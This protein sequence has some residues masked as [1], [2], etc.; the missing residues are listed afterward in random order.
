MSYDQFRAYVEIHLE[1]LKR[2]S[3]DHS[4]VDAWATGME[5]GNLGYGD[6]L[7]SIA[8]HCTRRTFGKWS[9][10]IFMDRKWTAPHY[11]KDAIGRAY[12]T[13]TPAQRLH[14]MFHA[15][16]IETNA[17][18]VKLPD[19]ATVTDEHFERAAT[20]IARITTESDMTIGLY[21]LN[22][23]SNYVAASLV[24]PKISGHEHGRYSALG[25]AGSGPNQTA[26]RPIEASP[27]GSAP[28]VG[29]RRGAAARPPSRDTSQP[30][31]VPRAAI[32]LVRKDE[33]AEVAKF[34]SSG[35]RAILTADAKYLAAELTM[36]NQWHLVLE[37]PVR[38]NPDKKGYLL[39]SATI[40]P[41]TRRIKVI[42]HPSDT[43]RA[44]EIV[45]IPRFGI[46]EHLAK[47]PENVAVTILALIFD[48]VHN[49]ALRS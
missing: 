28:R 29:K 31:P 25:S 35:S 45:T 44:S 33:C 41:Q 6:V 16:G 19:N 13:A 32:V 1:V 8:A 4:M 30:M 22:V 5:K 46:H 34:I 38:I 12:E 11:V 21:A 14:A 48:D 23:Q 40:I 20:I 24:A 3:V 36:H 26:Q 49:L 17:L 15:F 43:F 2:G 39:K 9:R 27:E 37:S 47:S 42:L 7:D 10:L 18:S